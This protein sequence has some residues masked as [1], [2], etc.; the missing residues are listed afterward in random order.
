MINKDYLEKLKEEDYIA[1]DDLTN[2]PMVTGG[3][4]DYRGCFL[5]AAIGV[6]CIVAAVFSLC[7][8]LMLDIRIVACK[9]N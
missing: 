2:D 6:I 9:Y 5:L 8:L 1:Y 3:G 7:W 4:D